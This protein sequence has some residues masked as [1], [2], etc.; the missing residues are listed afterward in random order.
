MIK[1]D[2]GYASCNEGMGKESAIELWAKAVSDAGGRFFVC[3]KG[4]KKGKCYVCLL[5]THDAAEDP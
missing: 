4:G 2:P 1:P 5:Y 3:G